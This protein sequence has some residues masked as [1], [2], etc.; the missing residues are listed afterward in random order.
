M[1]VDAQIGQDVV[2]VAARCLR[3]T[4]ARQEVLERLLGVAAPIRC[5]LVRRS[6]RQ[7]GKLIEHRPTVCDRVLDDVEDTLNGAASAFGCDTQR[8]QSRRE[9]DGLVCREPRAACRRGDLLRDSENVRL[10]RDGGN[11]H[12]VNGCGQLVVLR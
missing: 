7:R 11:A 4:K 10:S 6:A 12:L 9:R 8:G 5:E 2:D 3:P 1:R